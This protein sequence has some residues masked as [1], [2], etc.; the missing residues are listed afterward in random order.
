MQINHNN[1]VKT[2]KIRGVYM[3]INT[4]TITRLQ[5]FSIQLMPP[6][7]GAQQILST[8]AQPTW[9]TNNIL[10]QDSTNIHRQVDTMT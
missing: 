5:A 8:P 6:C 1:I 9:D 10:I 2:I 3:Q 4:K 7:W